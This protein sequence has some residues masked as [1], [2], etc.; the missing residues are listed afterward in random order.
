MKQQLIKT[1]QNSFYQRGQTLVETMVASMVLVMGISAA[2]GLAIYGLNATSG[3]TKQLVAVG[4]AR[5]GVEAVKNMRDTNWIR[6]NLSSSCFDFYTQ[7]TGA[8]CYQDW[9]SGAPGG[10]NINPGLGGELEYTIGFNEASNTEN[11]YWIISPESSNYGLTF[12]GNGG[13]NGFYS[14]SG[15]PVISSNSG[16]GRKITITRDN[17]LPVFNQATLGPRLLVQV[18]VWWTDKRCPAVNNPPSNP[19]CKITLETYLTNWKDY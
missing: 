13:S 17:S 8:F 14:P 6:G 11:S 15:N 12:N 16:Y 7:T 9:L 18:D 3:V 10:Y 19:A 5:E 1:N 2:A 4:L